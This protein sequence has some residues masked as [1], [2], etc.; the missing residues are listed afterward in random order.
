M[1]SNEQNVCGIVDSVY[2]LRKMGE[3]QCSLVDVIHVSFSH[4][5][6]IFQEDSKL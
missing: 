2:W 4:D 1:L 3:V 5:G 6:Q